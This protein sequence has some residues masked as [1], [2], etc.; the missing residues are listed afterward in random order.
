MSADVFPLAR[1]EC[2]HLGWEGHNPNAT[3]PC[4]AYTLRPVSD[5]ISHFS[6]QTAMPLTGRPFYG[7]WLTAISP[8]PFVPVEW[9]S[10]RQPFSAGAGV[11]LH[12]QEWQFPIALQGG[13]LETH[14]DEHPMK[15]RSWSDVITKEMVALGNCRKP[16]PPKPYE[17]RSDLI[18]GGLL[19]T[20]PAFLI[21]N[22][23][24]YL[25]RLSWYLARR[26]P[27]MTPDT[28]TSTSQY[29]SSAITITFS[30][31]AR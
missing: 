20:A 6:R 3:F 7:R 5:E 1:E 31:V 10:P 21:E 26:C 13:V 4:V 24:H 18:L 27:A 28:Q 2:V 8:C 22:H 19:T 9:A 23:I 16:M 30:C 12:T 15:H 17:G 11:P 29:V 25:F 14:H